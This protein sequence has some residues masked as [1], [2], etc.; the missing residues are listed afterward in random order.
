MNTSPFRHCPQ[1]R[2]GEIEFRD[3]KQLVC[4]NC[5]FCY[6]HNVA[7]A[8]GAIIRHGSE[9]LLAVRSREPAQGML[10]LPGGFTDPGESLEQALQR[11][12]REELGLQLNQ[13]RYLFS[14]A[15]TYLYAG[16]LYQTTDIIFEFKVSSKP[17][18]VPADDV[19]AVRWLELLDVKQEEIAF[20]SIRRAIG[21]LQRQQRHQQQQ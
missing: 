14:F 5:N 19:A 9:I 7:T 3:S 16:V 15:N 18:V 20:D 11:E 21:Q 8:V 2:S 12:L 13:P 1:C 6:F 4:L 17:A 10:D